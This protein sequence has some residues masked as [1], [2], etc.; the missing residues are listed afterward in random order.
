MKTIHKVAAIV[1]KDNSFLMVRK[2]GKCTWTNL[3]GHIEE[4]ETEEQAL[5]REI[6]EELN[7][8]SNIIRKLD[9]FKAKAAHDDAMLTLSTYLVELMGD[10]VINDPELEEFKYIPR[11]YREQG[12]KMPESIEKH[13]VPYLIENKL[14]LSK[15]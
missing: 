10:P 4:G 3:G 9:D 11:E 7:C 13:V 14:L 1:I 15:Y 6:L 12:Y 8:D 2:V 5:K